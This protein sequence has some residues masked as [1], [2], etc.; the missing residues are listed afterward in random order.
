MAYGGSGG[1]GSFY[2]TDAWVEY[3]R[4]AA[5]IL[6]EIRAIPPISIEPVKPIRV[7]TSPKRV[8]FN[9][10]AT[11]ILWTDGSKTVVKCKNGE[12][13]DEW[14]GFITAYAKKAFGRK[15][16]APFVRRQLKNAIRQEKKDAG[17]D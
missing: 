11:I 15:G 6:D 9:P 2:H 3:K 1:S 14:T 16:F 17:K 12:E 8:I 5:D 4:S 10:P 13:F 7:W